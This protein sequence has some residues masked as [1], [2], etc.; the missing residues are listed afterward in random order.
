[1]NNFLRI[2]KEHVTNLSSL[3][4]VPDYKYPFKL[5]D[6]ADM[7]IDKDYNSRLSISTLNDSEYS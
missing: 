7:T 3:K 4:A 2:E 1:M 5:D 6:I